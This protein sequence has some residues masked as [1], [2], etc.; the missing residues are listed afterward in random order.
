MWRLIIYISGIFLGNFSVQTL[1]NILSEF[2]CFDFFCLVSIIQF[3]KYG[4]VWA[5]YLD[6]DRILNYI[7]D[8]LPF[9]AI[10]IVLST[11]DVLLLFRTWIPILTLKGPRCLFFS[12]STFNL[13]ARWI[14]RRQGDTYINTFIWIYIYIYIYIYIL[15]CVYVCAC[16]CVERV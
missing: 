1:I 7:K 6:R 14:P 16:V 15:V 5:I 10:T 3:G 13:F 11:R 12:W 9:I 2:A 8:L 4:P